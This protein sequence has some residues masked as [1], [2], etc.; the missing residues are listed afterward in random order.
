MSKGTYTLRMEDSTVAS[1]CL[2]PSQPRDSSTKNIGAPGSPFALWGSGE[3]PKSICHVCSPS[4]FFDQ[5][6][7]GAAEC[8]ATLG[9]MFLVS[10][11]K[12]DTK[13]PTESASRSTRKLQTSAA[14]LISALGLQAV[15]LPRSPA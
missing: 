12:L 1:S 10:S 11:V 13:L 9:A 2:P 15:S 8:S 7:P 5:L 6:E 14:A 3:E 4:E